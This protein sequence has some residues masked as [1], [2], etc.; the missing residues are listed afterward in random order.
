MD[1]WDKKPSNFNTRAL[2][3]FSISYRLLTLSTVDFCVVGSIVE[4][5]QPQTSL[6]ILE[7]VSYLIHEASS[8]FKQVQLPLI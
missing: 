1:G 3:L 2:F 8:M 7:D 5:P 4:V 6:K